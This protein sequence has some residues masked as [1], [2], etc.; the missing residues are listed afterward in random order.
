MRTITK[1]KEQHFTTTT[2]LDGTTEVQNTGD[3]YFVIFEESDGYTSEE[4]KIQIGEGDVTD[5][6]VTE[7]SAVDNELRRVGQSTMTVEEFEFY[8]DLEWTETRIDATHTEAE[9]DIVVE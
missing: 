3:K 6:G 7:L 4:Y 8:S 5:G 2:F 9:E 1:I